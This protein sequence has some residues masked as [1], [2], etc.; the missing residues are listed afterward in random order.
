MKGKILVVI[1]LLIG[2]C[3]L[4]LKSSFFKV[5]EVYI[6]GNSDIF[7]SLAFFKKDRNLLLTSTVAFSKEIQKNYPMVQ[8]VAIQKRFP[9][10]LWIEIEEREPVF[11]STES[12]APLFI[13]SAG[14]L[15]PTFER[16]KAKEP[17]RLSCTLEKIEG[18]RLTDNSLISLLSFVSQLKNDMLP[19]ISHVVCK[20][21]KNAALKI[22]TTTIKLSL[23]IQKQQILTNSLQFLFKQFR[24]EGKTPRTIDV[25]FTKPVLHFEQEQ[26]A[27]VSSES[28]N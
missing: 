3:F 14:F 19:P 26:V 5:R 2:V 13:D 27:S 6:V 4:I 10:T 28:A 11:I 15:V 9:N 23:P 24:I 21:S 1:F 22:G 16:F 18:G 20:D 8:T 7:P 12:E 17:I 25:R